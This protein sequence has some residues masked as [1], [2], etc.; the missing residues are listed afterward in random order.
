MLVVTSFWGAEH[1]KQV[2]AA[3]R[4]RKRAPT[5]PFRPRTFLYSAKKVRAGCRWFPPT[6]RRSIVRSSL[7][8]C[9]AQTLGAPFSAFTQL[10]PRSVQGL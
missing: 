3:L 9:Q 7:G 2:L 5:I 1:S 4:R 10:S 6:L 8:A